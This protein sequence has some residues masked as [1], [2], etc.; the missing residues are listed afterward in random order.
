MSK[1]EKE[2]EK[3]A[4]MQE[5]LEQMKARVI[6]QAERMGVAS[7][8]GHG[9]QPNPLL[10]NS[11]ERKEVNISSLVPQRVQTSAFRPFMEIPRSPRSEMMVQ[12]QMIMANNAPRLSMQRSNPDENHVALQQRS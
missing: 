5:Q 1:E 2:Q 3:Y 10:S 11:E 4:R 6:I 9:H 12:T 7:V 8:D